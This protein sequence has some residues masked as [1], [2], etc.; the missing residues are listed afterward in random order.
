MHIFFTQWTLW[1]KQ[2]RYLRTFTYPG[3]SSI[4]WIF[5][6]MRFGPSFSSPAL[7][8]VYCFFL[9][10]RFHVPQI[11]PPSF[12]AR[13]SFCY[14]DSSDQV[15]SK[16]VWR[17]YIYTPLGVHTASHYLT[18]TP[19]NHTHTVWDGRSRS[20]SITSSRCEMVG[21]GRCAA[22]RSPRQTAINDRF[23]NN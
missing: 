9:V 11:Q 4:F 2:Y 21:R 17:C 8:S 3:P 7:F 14:S 22:E 20:Q 13:R 12:P 23:A 10:C 15:S 5:Q 16:I 1:F 19:T 6:S 18:K